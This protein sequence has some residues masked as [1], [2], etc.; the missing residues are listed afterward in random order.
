[1]APADSQCAEKRRV[2]AYRWAAAVVI[3]G[4]AAL[5]VHFLAND[6][7]FDLAPDEAHYWQWAQNLDWSYYSKGPLVAWL[8][9]L[10]TWLAGDWSLAL[11]GSEMLAV[12]LPAVVCGALLLA[13][14]YVLTVQ[15]YRS[16]RLALA[17]VAVALTLP[18]VA[19]GSTVMTIDAPFTCLWCWALVLGHRA[20]FRNAVWAWPALGLALGLGVLA[21]YTMVIW[22]AACGL[23][24][25]ATPKYRNL[26]AR[27]GSW[28]CMLILAICCV[29]V[30]YWN[31]RHDWVGVRH[32]SHLAAGQQIQLRLIWY[33]PLLYLAT[34]FVLLLGFWFVAWARALWAAQP[35]RD[36][37][38]ERQFL[39]WLSIFPFAVFL[40][41]SPATGGGEANWPLPAYL[42]GLVLTAGW[43]AEEGQ[44]ARGW[45]RRAFRWSVAVACALGLA[46]TAL[47]YEAPQ[48]TPTLSALAPAP[49]D[50][51]PAPVRSFD[52]TSR[53]R[54]WRTL[55]EE[56][57]DELDRLRAQGIEPVIAAGTWTI[58]G[59]LA[60][61]SRHKV[62]VHCVGL[63]LGCRHSQYD[64]WRPNP[65]FDQ[66][67][68]LGRTFLFVGDPAPLHR[69]HAFEQIGLTRFVYHREGGVPL[70][71]WQI[72]LCRGFRG[73]RF[74]PAANRQY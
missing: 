11:T 25:L 66:E 43:L 23:F 58:P 73:F 5:R 36:R 69:V 6:C 59:E 14:L 1:M 45:Y 33:G 55:A 50:T 67:L 70:A 41:F 8:I 49:T 47:M 40:I 21:K 3:V 63:P 65:V 71:R 30:L 68:Y 20:I 57:D 27:P 61:Y 46:V 32:V 52:P 48:F 37:D 12:R 17:V 9:R 60:F 64:L 16:D 38:P 13:G 31:L 4:A 39:W 29:P 24:L 42:S 51:N 2:A 22:P 28:L 7:P 56:V 53:L 72:T 35:G 26:L 54:G 62:Q 19:V 74:D 44:A 34:Q 10:S 18:P 15:V